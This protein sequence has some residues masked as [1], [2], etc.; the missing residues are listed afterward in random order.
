M[1]RFKPGLTRVSPDWQST[2]KSAAMSRG[3][4]LDFL[5]AVGVHADETSDAELGAGARV[6]ELRAFPDRPLVN[7]NMGQLAVR[8]LLEL[9][10]K[11][12]GVRV[13]VGAEDDFFFPAVEVIGD[14]LDLGRVREVSDHGIKEELNPL[15]LIG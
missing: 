3:R 9:K 2:P 10:G 8:P 13:R 15:I 12:D 5:H 6:Q 7:A 11:S 1:A 4:R 14:V